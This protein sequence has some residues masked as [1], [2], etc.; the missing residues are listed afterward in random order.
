MAKGI[1]GTSEECS[2]PDCTGRAVGWGWC[3]KHWQRWRKYGDPLGSAPPRR[4]TQLLKR[5]EHQQNGCIYMTGNIRP[6][7]YARISNQGA[8]RVAYEYFIG[9]IPEAHDVDHDC[10]NRADPPCHL[11]PAC[12]HRR[13]VNPDHLRAVPHKENVLAG[14]SFG[15]VNAAKT[16]CNRGHEF[17]PENTHFES[18]G[19]RRCRV[20]RRLR[21]KAYRDRQRAKR[22]I[23]VGADD[24]AQV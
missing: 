5:M 11:G 10:H 2:I 20:C 13:C 4:Y 21:E 14:V 3:Q 24:P 9:P 1:K 12:P 23:P 6:D 15:A 17:T 22:C 19:G 18:G 7:G 16:H 8:H